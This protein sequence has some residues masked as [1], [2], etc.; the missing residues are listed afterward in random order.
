MSTYRN[1]TAMGEHACRRPQYA[2]AYAEH[3]DAVVSPPST[4]AVSPGSP[5][6][7]GVHA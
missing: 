6:F 7:G 4:E 1:A 5:T 2:Y 3:T